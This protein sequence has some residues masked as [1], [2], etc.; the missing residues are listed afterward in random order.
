[1]VVKLLLWECAVNLF[2]MGLNSVMCQ[3]DASKNR[4]QSRT[5]IRKAVLITAVKN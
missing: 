3:I 1:M 4:K 5:K 2:V